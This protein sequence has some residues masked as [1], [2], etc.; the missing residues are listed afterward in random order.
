MGYSLE[1]NSKWSHARYDPKDAR[2][3]CVNQQRRMMRQDAMR[4]HGVRCEVTRNDV[5]REDRVRDLP[6]RHEGLGAIL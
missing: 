2:M 1:P 5:F 4:W 3:G 6:I